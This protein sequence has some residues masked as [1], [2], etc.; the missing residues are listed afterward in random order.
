MTMCSPTY[1]SA[2]SLG[3]TQRAFTLIELAISLAIMSILIVAMGSTVM[4]ATNALPNEDDPAWYVMDASRGVGCMAEELRTAVHMTER[5]VHAVT[6]TVADRNGDGIWERIR[7]AW[8]GVAGAPVTRQYNNGS[9]AAVID[10]V[11][12][13][14]LGYELKTVTEEYPGPLVESDEMELSSY[15]VAVNPRVSIIRSGKWPGQYFEPLLPAN[16]VSWSVTRLLFKAK[17]EGYGNGTTFVQLRP[18]FTEYTVVAPIIEQHLP[19]DTVLEQHTMYEADLIGNY[20]WREFS[21][22]SVAGLAPDI[23]LC[24]VLQWVSNDYS[25]GILYDNVGGSGRFQTNDAGESW[26]YWSDKG[27]CHYVYGKVIANAASQTASRQYITAVHATIQTGESSDSR[28]DT[29]VQTMN[30]PEALSAVWEADFNADPTLIDLN[31][32]AIADWRVG[33][34]TPFDVDQ[35]VDGVFGAHLTLTTNPGFDFTELTTVDIRLRDTQDEGETGGI[36]LRIDRT[37]DTYGYIRAEV[38]RVADG[39]QTLMRASAH[40]C[41]VVWRDHTTDE[42]CLCLIFRPILYRMPPIYQ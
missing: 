25:A 20:T 27:L 23:G 28:I 22:S 7:Y 2:N 21:F 3:R 26:S 10:N 29:A 33:N 19:T 13:F 14:D 35:L 12:Q 15:G 9:P 31:G 6:F 16:V 40:H 1:R 34:G 37:G 17:C 41:I 36:R 30:A 4:L 39:S 32:D 42:Y 8:S 24:I 11:H 18:S 38:D 5:S